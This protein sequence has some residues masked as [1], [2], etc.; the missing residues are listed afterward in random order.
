MGEKNDRACMDLDLSSTESGAL[1]NQKSTESCLI[2]AECQECWHIPGM[3]FFSP[4]CLGL[5]K[6][7]LFFM[8]HRHGS[9][10]AQALP[11]QACLCLL[12]LLRLCSS[13]LF[14]TTGFT[15][16]ASRGVLVKGG[17]TCTYPALDIAAPH[18]WAFGYK[19]SLRIPYSVIRICDSNQLWR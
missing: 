8:P 18:S 13:L 6:P 5:P 16:I 12:P 19:Y 11:T 15:L 2:Y 1:F 9:Q 14:F 17:W 3:L 7:S 10:L 4:C